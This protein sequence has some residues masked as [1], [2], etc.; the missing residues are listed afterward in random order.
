VA[1]LFLFSWSHGVDNPPPT[2]KPIKEKV[3]KVAYS[4]AL[5]CEDQGPRVHLIYLLSKKKKKK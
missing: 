2:H 1:I 5:I 3:D 4:N